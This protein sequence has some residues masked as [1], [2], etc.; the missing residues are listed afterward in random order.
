VSIHPDGA[1]ISCRF[2]VAPAA[3]HASRFSFPGDEKTLALAR[4]E[5]VE[6]ENGISIILI[7]VRG[8]KVRLGI[9]APPGLN[10]YRI[11]HPP[12]AS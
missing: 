12:A 5:F 10:V 3:P 8:E 2:S 7:E 9:S 1:A 6:I 11:E 4:N